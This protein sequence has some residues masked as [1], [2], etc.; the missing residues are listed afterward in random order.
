MRIN[1]H[2]VAAVC[3]KAWG[4]TPRRFWEMCNA[5][6]VTFQQVVAQCHLEMLAS[7]I[8]AEVFCEWLIPGG[9]QTKQRKK[10]QQLNSSTF[11]YLRRK[12]DGGKTASHSTT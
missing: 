8:T 5:G 2:G 10:H 1:R 7:P 9:K 4:I 12:R 6:E 11:E 3:S